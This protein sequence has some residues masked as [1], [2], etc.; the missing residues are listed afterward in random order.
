[1]LGMTRVLVGRCA[2]PNDG[3]KQP[4]A[5]FIGGRSTD[6]TLARASLIGGTLA[7]LR[8]LVAVLCTAFFS[9]EETLKLCLRNNFCKLSGLEHTS[10]Y[11][12]NPH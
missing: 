2:R 3:I 12:D 6:G 11:G 10:M 5:S 4:S 7:R 1:M 9:V 8:S